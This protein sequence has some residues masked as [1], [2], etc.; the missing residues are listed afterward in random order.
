MK[1]GE[2]NVS[3]QHTTNEKVRS[4]RDKKEEEGPTGTRTSG[5]MKIALKNEWEKMIVR[6]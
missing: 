4:H 5:D 6:H 1:G 2:K 3:K